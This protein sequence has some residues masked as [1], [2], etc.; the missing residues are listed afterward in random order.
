MAVA[1]AALSQKEHESPGGND[2]GVKQN[3]GRRYFETVR[4]RN[5]ASGNTLHPA[6]I[7]SW[8]IVD[9]DEER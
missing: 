8:G 9:D 6:L 5:I 3:R 4:Y 2:G 1:R 7:A